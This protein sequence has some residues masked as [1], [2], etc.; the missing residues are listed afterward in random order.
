MPDR[1]VVYTPEHVARLA[2]CV[3]QTIYRH[4]EKGEFPNARQIGPRKW[5]IPEEDVINYLGYD[6]KEIQIVLAH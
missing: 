2:Q 5:F 3:V 1:R 6:P 4:I